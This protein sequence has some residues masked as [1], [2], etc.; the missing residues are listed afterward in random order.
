MALRAPS[1]CSRHV[2]RLLHKAW[3]R[4]PCQRP[5]NTHADGL[6]QTKRRSAAAHTIAT[7]R[8]CSTT[9]KIRRMSLATT[10]R[11]PRRSTMRRK[12]FKDLGLYNFEVCMAQHG[13]LGHCASGERMQA[14][15]GSSDDLLACTA[16]LERYCPA[17]PACDC[18]CCGGRAA[19][20]D[21]I[22]CF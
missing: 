8:R 5:A 6:V 4:P 11:T 21:T 16:A 14:A 10:S 19:A 3:A 17:G 9:P 18:S 7:G 22:S 13:F 20:G 1:Y 15:M 12:G 2:R